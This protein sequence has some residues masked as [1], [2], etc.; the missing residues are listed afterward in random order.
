MLFLIYSAVKGVDK[1]RVLV[2]FELPG[3]GDRLLQARKQLALSQCEVAAKAGCSK[4]TVSR[5]EKEMGATPLPTLKAIA[6]AVGLDLE[7]IG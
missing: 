4:A 5:A 3:M 2:E 6:G 1:V 7:Q